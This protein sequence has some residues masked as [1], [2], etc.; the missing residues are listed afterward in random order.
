[1]D[2]LTIVLSDDLLQLLLGK[3]GLRVD[4]VPPCFEH[5]CADLVRGI[6]QEDLG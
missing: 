3:S 5:L 4:N 2:L 1:M 6:A